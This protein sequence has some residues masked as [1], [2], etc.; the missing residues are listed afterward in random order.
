MKFI[1]LASDYQVEFEE[2]VKR[3]LRIPSV[4]E[5]DERYPFGKPVDDVLKE[6]LSIGQEDGFSVK[7]ISGYAGH[8]EYG[9][10]KGLIGILGHLDVVPAGGGWSSNPFEPVI[11]DGKLFARGAQDDKGPVMAAYI[12]MKLLKDQGFEPKKRVRLII[13]TDEERDWQ[14]IDYYFRQEEMPEFG[15][16]PD[17]SFP[18]IHAEKG[19][20]DGY[21]RLP[22]FNQSPDNVIQVESMK[23]GDRLNMVPETAKAKLQVSAAY[24]LEEEFK[25]FLHTRQVKGEIN[26]YG[27]KVEVNIKG[28]GVHASKP[29]QGINAVI[30]LAKFLKQLPLSKEAK[31][32][33]SWL[34]V[35]FGETT[36]ANFGINAQDKASGALTINL[37]SFAY[38]NG[39]IT[40]GI[41]IRYPVT[42]DGEGIINK[43]KETAAIQ[44]GSYELY[45]HLFPLYMDEDHPGV[46]TL[47]DIFNK[48]TGS[49]RRAEA[50]GGATYARALKAGVAYG[51]M[52]TDSPDTAHQTDEHV[53]MD[54]MIKAIAIYAEAIYQLSK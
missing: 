2:K 15:F 13:G 46:K 41:N 23:G 54:D 3:I 7:N 1:T 42:S 34:A 50:I 31:E 18:V 43:M 53:R 16:S 38:Q 4:Y 17:A 37:G 52:F 35:Q 44:K 47:L 40:A 11:R 27:N 39:D 25:G 5:D 32:F 21:L 30:D 26:R 12:A 51:A 48:Q 24:N 20:I 6:M 19:L 49:E 22:S 9:H 29:E 45:D 36:G 10:G 28:K 14:G 8:I 33:F